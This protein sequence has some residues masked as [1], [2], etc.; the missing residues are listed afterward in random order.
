LYRISRFV[1]TALVAFAVSTLAA[2][3]AT[4]GIDAR[5]LRMPDVSAT[6]I[7]FVYAGDVWVVPKDGGVARRLST[8]A[9]EEYFPRFSHDGTRIAFTGNYDGNNDV[10]VVPV[11]GGLPVRVTHHPASDHLI[12]WYPD[13]GALLLSTSMTSGTS[14]YNQLYRTSPAGGMPEKLPVPYGEFGAVSPDGR[15]LAYMP[16]SRDFRTWKRYRG[17][18]VSQIWLFGLEDGSWHNLSDSGA[19][20]TQPMWRGNS[21]LYFLSDRG[22]HRRYNLWVTSLEDGATRQ[23]THFQ[24]YD[25]HFPAIGPEEIVFEN[26]GRLYLFDLDSEEPREVEVEVVTDRSTLRPRVEKVADLIRSAD[27][28][29]S[30][31]RAVFEARG[32][33]FTVP[34][35]HGI[36]RNLTRSSGAAERYPVWSPDGEWIAYLSDRSGEY[37]LTLRP[38][39]GSGDER[40]LTELGP[41]YRYRPWWSPDS[42]K[43]VFVDQEMNVQLYD[44]DSGELR[45]VDRGRFLYHGSLSNFRV[46]WS[47]DSRWLAFSRSL[48]TSISAVFLYDTEKGEL[49]QVTSGFYDAFSPAFDPGGDYLY[50]LWNRAFVPSVGSLQFQWIYADG[51]QVAAIPLRRDVPSPVAPRNDVE[52]GKGEDENGED[53]NGKAEGNED[54]NSKAKKGGKKK[55]DDGDDEA[56]KPVEIDLEGLEGRL[57]VLPIERG[58]YG[59]LTAAEGKVVY[60]RRPRTGSTDQ[61]FPTGGGQVAYWDL[62]KREEKTVVENADGYALAAGGGK[63]LVQRGS[64]FAIVD[65]APD[66]KLDQKLATD[67]LEMTVDPRAEW[68]QLFTDAWRLERD[69]FYDPGLHGVDWEEMRRR[70]GALLEDAVTRWDVHFV[71]GEMIAELGA[72]HTYRFGGDTDEAEQRQVGLLGAD[73]TLEDGCFRLARII[74]LPSWESEVRSPLRRPG[75]DVE[76]GECLLAVDGA[77]LDLDLDPWAAFQGKAGQT[78][79]L[80]VNDRPTFD[81]ARELLVE[82]L[83]DERRLRHLAWIEKNRRRVAEATG[84]RVG[85]VYV[86]DTGFN[87]HTELIRQFRSQYLHD[88]L[89]VDERFNGGGF[90]PERMI[91]L[92]DRP[93]FYYRAVRSEP[94]WQ[95]PL[96][97]HHGPKAMLINGWAGSGG[98]L[99]PFAFRHAGLGPL[100]G[101]RTWGGVIGLAGAPGLI[102]GGFVT[103][104]T[105]GTYSADGEWIIEGYGVDPDVEVLNDPTSMAEGRDPQLDKAIEHILEELEKNPHRRP[106]KPAYPVDPGS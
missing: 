30:G 49:H 45:Q 62:E 37:E 1:P 60:L 97:A 16:W 50:L 105:H 48:E 6:Q 71:I 15:T 89:I 81:G 14:R 65:L 11:A 87:G 18:R 53:E 58:S 101:T 9:G 40:T 104:P 34:A 54:K 75:L 98:D 66:Q 90:G 51:F 102:D 29:P 23:L 95:E 69:F 61:P 2:A 74:E 59:L 63:L 32:E 55:A 78:V 77:P 79:L 25:V 19:N 26:A 70:Y 80:T 57:E 73:F 46:S 56:P 41:G 106:A 38:A 17:G 83:A 7:A 35:E 43:L 68:R 88:G 85:Y 12:D 36:V 31:K 8:P 82:T 42:E 28:S 39:D 93:L 33:V 3:P 44:L 22:E 5:L 20:D 91:E 64:D 99:L 86:P 96:L 103:V 84:G 4:A 100:I 27:L 47:P 10:Y 52:E 92:L 67:R 13:D 21:H 76:E 24:E 72:S 94:D